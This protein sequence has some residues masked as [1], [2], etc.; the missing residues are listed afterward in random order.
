MKGIHIEDILMATGGKIIS[1][2]GNS[3][4]FSNISIDSRNISSGELFI[5]LKG[6]RFDGHN[7]IYKALEKA[8]GALVS[9][10]PQEL[11]KGKTVILVKNTLTALQNIAHAVRIRSK[12]P[13]VAITGT[14]GKTTTKEMIASILGMKYRV[15][16]NTGNLNNH[17]GLPLS[18]TKL[19]DEDEIVVLEMGA[20]APGDIRELCRIAVPDYGVITNIGQ[21]HLE[22]FG[23]IETVRRTKLELLETV[24]GIVLNADD[25]FLME[26]ISD[27]YGKV[28]TFGIEN[29]A[30]VFA[31]DINIRERDSSFLLCIGT[32]RCIEVNLKMIGRFNIANAL[33]AAA[34]ADIFNIDM[35]EIKAGIESF[36][37]VPMRLELTEQSGVT[38]IS[39]VYNANP[40][41]MEYAVKELVRL[42][43]ERAVAVLGDMLELGA[44]AEQL[45]KKLGAWMAQMPVDVF[46]A[47][48]P[49]MAFAE[50]EF[51]RSGKQSFRA[52]DASEAGSILAGISKQGDSILVKGS[53]AMEME[54]VIVK[55]SLRGIQE[56]AK[57]AL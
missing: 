37:A 21:A 20:S 34:I 39:D 14:N 43:K 44:S 45:H 23:N 2:N 27:Y 38:V 40:S 36:H 16:R 50:S 30:D 19:T 11:P 10:L 9:S 41:S 55:D 28:I 22:G 56:E 13:V 42:R 54:K 8:K 4:I 12:I 49:L 32:E 52:V 53:R 33:A 51:R 17:I 35:P 6:S 24:S 31:R 46:I 1:S 5:A 48:G 7:F 15:L 18:L 3:G 29:Q 57:N 25:E 26:G 47:V